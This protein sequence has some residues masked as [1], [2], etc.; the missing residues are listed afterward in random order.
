MAEALLRGVNKKALEFFNG[1]GKRYLVLREDLKE[2]QFTA[3]DLGD[4]EVVRLQKVAD[5][6]RD[7]MS[8]DPKEF[9]RMQKTWAEYV[10][11]YSRM[12]ESPLTKDEELPKLQ[13]NKDEAQELLNLT[14]LFGNI[15]NSIRKNKN[16]A[17]IAANKIR[18]TKEKII[19]DLSGRDYKNLRSNI[20]LFNTA[21]DAYFKATSE[22]I[23]AEEAYH[24]A[25]TSELNEELVEPLSIGEVEELYFAIR[26][27]MNEMNAEKAK[28]PSKAPE[29][30]ITT[31]ALDENIKAIA[32]LVGPDKL[33][34][35]RVRVEEKL[36]KPTP[37]EEELEKEVEQKIIKTFKNQL[38]FAYGKLFK[39]TKTKYQS[40]N[41]EYS[42]YDNALL[43]KQNLLYKDFLEIPFE[44]KRQIDIEMNKDYIKHLRSH[45]GEEQYK[46]ISGISRIRRAIMDLNRLPIDSPEITTKYNEVKNMVEE[47]SKTPEARTVNMTYAISDSDLLR[48][49]I[50][51]AN[52]AS[53]TMPLVTKEL[54]EKLHAPKVEPKKETPKEEPKKEE[55]KPEP[56]KEASKPERKPEPKKEE[57][58]P[59]FAKPTPSEE[60]D[61]KYYLALLAETNAQIAEINR[62][63][64][65]LILHNKLSELSLANI[66]EDVNV[67]TTAV[68]A[69][70]IVSKMRV[71]L[72]EARYN[73]L[74]K[75][76][77]YILSNPEV[78]E[79]KIN[80]IVFET[81]FE[82]FIAERDELIIDAELRINK[83]R[84][85]KPKGYEE[86]INSL[87]EFIKAQNSLISRFL[88]AE[89][90]ARKIDI[91]KFLSERNE[92]RKA[93]VDSK[94]KEMGETKPLSPEP[95]KEEERKEEPKVEPKVEPK[96][97]TPK[98]EEKK[99]PV[100]EEPR[101]ENKNPKE[102]PEK[103][104]DPKKGPIYEGY[105]LEHMTPEQQ[106]EQATGLKFDPEKYEVVYGNDA[107]DDGY[108][109][110]IS[111]FKVVPIEAAKK[112]KKEE[113]PVDIAHVK[114]TVKETT[115]RFNPRNEKEVAKRINKNDRLFVDSPK[116]TTTLIKNGVRIEISK[117][118]RERLAELNAKIRLVNNKIH[119]SATS[120]LVDASAES[121]DIQ[122]KKDHDVDFDNY[123][124]EVR[125]PGNKESYVLL[126]EEEQHHKSM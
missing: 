87:L 36:T 12:L 56:K 59:P 34:E 23:V 86:E 65:L 26:T 51:D 122:F 85:E 78:R 64:S 10:D 28:N 66:A 18:A 98:K 119:Q 75:H 89:S 102:K 16:D 76:G 115:L 14:N 60:E 107:Y 20:N 25:T 106:F 90:I 79:A 1:R 53:I 2:H 31:I 116:I 97:E 55:V 91:T 58:V 61:L 42:G 117:N 24:Q 57:P 84:E 45:F 38:S 39:E 3:P 99:E 120:R 35:I 105:I 7:R 95:K 13:R 8:K 6:V 50:N 37:S 15:F 80:E 47:L 113:K 118:L 29:L 109:N 104:E 71:E 30:E 81:D 44:V 108:D 88:V 94:L 112:E 100:K 67:E 125:I 96:K 5:V 46:V 19:L 83:L 77:K 52:I 62:I 33:K 9:E 124:V 111:T 70:A 48:I 121:Q 22:I 27:A 114:V 17:T 82:K 54:Y 123:R 126:G 103:K 63:N 68:H 11:M 73:Y 110:P 93:L 74:K 49:E 69:S 4:L 40:E 101:K 32:R 41:W 92:R 43:V 21:V 72:S